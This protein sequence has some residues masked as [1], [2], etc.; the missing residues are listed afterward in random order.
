M[1]K[2]THRSFSPPDVGF[3]LSFSIQ[4]CDNNIFRQ[5]NM[6]ATFRYGS[7]WNQYSFYTLLNHPLTH[8]LFIR[9]VKVTKEKFS[10]YLI[11]QTF[12]FSTFYNYFFFFMY[13]NTIHTNLSHSLS[14]FNATLNVNK[15]NTYYKNKNTPF[16]RRCFSLRSLFPLILQTR[17]PFVWLLNSFNIVT[18]MTGD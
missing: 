4:I 12:P 8:K 1:K 2:L 14:I 7:L 11:P 5:K 18:I 17:R 15:L 3:I 16:L 6:K 13:Q 10:M 9:N